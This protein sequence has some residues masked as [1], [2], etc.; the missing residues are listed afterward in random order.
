MSTIIQSIQFGNYDWCFN[1]G[2][3]WLGL[4]E[5]DKQK[6]IL[7]VTIHIPNHLI[8]KV[9][10]VLITPADNHNILLQYT[11]CP[12]ITHCNFRFPVSDDLQNKELTA[13]FIRKTKRTEDESKIKYET[14][15]TCNFTCTNLEIKGDRDDCPICKD[16]FVS[17]Y[18]E[19]DVVLE[20]GHK[21]HLVCLL[22]YLKSKQLLQIFDECK[23]VG[24]KHTAI[25]KSFNCPCCRR[26]SN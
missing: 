10:R 16:G 18:H 22:D 9:D 5:N 13:H 25:P 4:T 1:T 11:V 26:E 24:C 14:L 19:G 21:F 7:S 2:K 3:Y 15:E 12:I 17:Q 6:Y 23:K 8:S 20:C